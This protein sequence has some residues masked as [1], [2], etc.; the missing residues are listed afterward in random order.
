MHL[1]ISQKY[2]TDYKLYIAGDTTDINYK[3]TLLSLVKENNLCEYV[4]FLGMR[5]DIC[6]LMA[7][8][9][10]LVVPSIYEGFGFITVE[11][12]FNGCLVIGNNSAGTKEILEPE[13]LGILYSGHDELVSAM[14]TVV[15]NGIESYFPM[16][17]KAQERAVA[18]YSQEQN[19][20]AVYKL[21]NEI[22]DNQTNT[23]V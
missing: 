11:A 21:Y 22:I 23:I 7:H 20:D 19:V 16:I 18:L 2:I 14:K 6:D 10:A 5:D 12:M 1:Q 13:N 15:E 4:V 9:T 17:M 3:Q 8:A